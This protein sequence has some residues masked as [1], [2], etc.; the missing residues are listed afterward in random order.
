MKSA[1]KGEKRIAQGTAVIVFT[2]VPRPGR[3][4]TRMMPYLDGEGCAELLTCFLTDIRDSLIR[5]GADII[6]CYDDGGDGK[7]EPLRSIFGS[8]VRY[9]PQRGSGLG[10][11][12]EAAFDDAFGLGY[13]SCLLMGSDIPEMRTE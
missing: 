12:M 3:V 7:A 6:V 2:R 13:T 10:Q 1:V 5:T 8:K 9:I 11:K 4:K